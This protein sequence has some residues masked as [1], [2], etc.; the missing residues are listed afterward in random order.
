MNGC[1]KIVF[2]LIVVTVNESVTQVV[3]MTVARPM[4]LQCRIPGVDGTRVC[5]QVGVGRLDDLA[6]QMAG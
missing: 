2:N 1:G 4:M 5:N 6:S 3:V